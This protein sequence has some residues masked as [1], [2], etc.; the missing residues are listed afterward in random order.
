M[1][2]VGRILE[3]YTQSGRPVSYTG[4]SPRDIAPYLAEQVAPIK[5]GGLRT[6]R[7]P[8]VSL[9]EVNFLVPQPIRTLLVSRRQ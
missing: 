8:H 2:T 9:V 6:A 3:T 5:Q 7:S 1:A 4:C